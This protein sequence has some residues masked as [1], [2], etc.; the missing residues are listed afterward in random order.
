MQW[1]VLLHLLLLALSAMVEGAAPQAQI[2]SWMTQ[3]LQELH[4]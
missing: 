1:G 3:Q 2:W 4:H